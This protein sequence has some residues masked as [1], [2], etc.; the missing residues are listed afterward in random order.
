MRAVIMAGGKGTRLQS[1]VTDIPKP[2]VRVCGKPVLEYQ[3]ESLRRCKIYDITI[4]TGSYGEVIESY[5]RD[6]SQWG[7]RIDYIREEMPLGTAG[8]LFFLKESMT[9]DF[10]LLFGDLMLNVDW[11]RFM[12][13]HK[14]KGAWITLYGHPST[15]P[16]DSDIIVT[17]EKGEVLQIDRKNNVREYFYHNFV[18]AGIYCLNPIILQTI[19]K[20]QKADLERDIVEKLI[21]GKKV[22]AY[23]S[24]EYVKDMGTP[25]RL[26]DVAEDVAK[27]IVDC[28]GLQNKQ[29]AVFLDRDGT[30]NEQRGFISNTE[31]FVLLPGV[32][33]AIRK[34]NASSYLTIIATN[35]PVIARG[36]CDLKGLREIHN[37][38]ETELGKMG[39]YLDDIFFCPHHPHKGY[40]GEVA[41]LKVECNCR[42]PKIGMLEKAAETYNIDLNQSWYIGDTTVD[43]RTGINAGMKTIL[44]HTGEAGRDGKYSVKPDYE[45]E[46]LTDAID[47]VLNE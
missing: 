41:E 14:A 23:K 7:M 35:Q 3:I 15:H 29:K 17:D 24:T 42:K 33:E 4:V 10:V 21:P 31:Q 25:D 45:A 12:A 36:E 43:I 46:T 40:E 19:E 5:F 13:F 6:G 22:Y 37:K 30:I 38:L 8:S 39:A 16:F 9:E 34:L 20:A 26:R 44:V 1:I 18:N 28:R 32:A 2:M 47:I 27:G 11:N